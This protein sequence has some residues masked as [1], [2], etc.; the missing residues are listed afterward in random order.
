MFAKEILTTTFLCV[1]LLVN[2]VA[3]KGGGSGGS[4]G[5]G[6]SDNDYG[7]G[8]GDDDPDSAADPQ[9][10]PLIHWQSFLIVLACLILFCA[11]CCLC[12]RNDR[13]RMLAK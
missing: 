11:C 10:T 2:A 13:N 12:R 7:N 4:G 9:S 3:G 6:K 1:S 5:G 8:D